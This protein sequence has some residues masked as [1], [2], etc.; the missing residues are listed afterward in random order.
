[1]LTNRVYAAGCV[2]K[3]ADLLHHRITPEARSACRQ[4][5][6]Y[7]LVEQKGLFF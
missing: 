1:M 4:A 3:P 5:R 6:N 2:S 7:L